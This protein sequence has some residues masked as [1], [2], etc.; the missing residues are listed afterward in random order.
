VTSEDRAVLRDVAL[1]TLAHVRGLEG[2]PEWVEHEEG[3]TIIA[4]LTGDGG[5]VRPVA[6][7]RACHAH[8]PWVQLVVMGPGEVAAI[9]RAGIPTGSEVV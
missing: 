6:A 2:L 3:V 8:E 5:P 9:A 4:R 1:R 7:V